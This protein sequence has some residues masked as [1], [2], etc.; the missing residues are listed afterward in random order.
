MSSN[1]LRMIDGPHPH[2]LPWKFLLLAL[3]KYVLHICTCTHSSL[4]I[5]CD[6]ICDRNT[7]DGSNLV[8]KKFC[9]NS[10]KCCKKYNV[11]I[12]CTVCMYTYMYMLDHYQIAV[13][14]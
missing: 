10:W 2:P 9:N 3:L 4:T 5:A 12:Y 11:N 8:S 1:A 7:N 6:A 14:L 13:I